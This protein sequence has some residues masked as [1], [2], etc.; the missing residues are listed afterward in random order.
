M[1]KSN[2]K[3]HLVRELYII[4]TN[5][6]YD[7]ITKR[8]M[9]QFKNCWRI[10]VGISAKRICQYPINTW[11]NDIISHQGNAIKPQWDVPSH[12]LGW[13][14]LK[15]Q[16]ITSVGK[17]LLKLK[18]AYTGEVQNSAVTL[19]YILAVSQTFKHRVTLWSSNFYF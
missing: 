19:E 17:D 10:W 11:K 5:K 6:S 18:L 4:Y 2:C 15:S 1:G 12:P 13:L 9:T 7:S 16:I 8:P 3:S 14:E